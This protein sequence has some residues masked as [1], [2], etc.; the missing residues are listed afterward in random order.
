MSLWL[1]CADPLGVLPH[2]VQYC[3]LRYSSPLPS[4]SLSLS[5]SEL[6]LSIYLYVCMY[7]SSYQS[8]IYLLIDTPNGKSAL[9]LL[10]LIDKYLEKDNHNW[11]L[12]I[13]SFLGMRDQVRIELD[14]WLGTHLQRYQIWTKLAINTKTKIKHNGI[15]IKQLIT[16][17]ASY[18]I[19][20]LLGF[21]ICHCLNPKIIILGYPGISRKIQA[22]TWVLTNPHCKLH[23]VE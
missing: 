10:G 18:I 20:G 11:K 17:F 8:S 22:S 7:L 13:S 6:P 9:F 19:L 5:F 15:K 4:P 23:K 1:T 2:N 14:I 21:N 16:S 3:C 12:R